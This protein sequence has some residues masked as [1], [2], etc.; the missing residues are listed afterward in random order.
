MRS[1]AARISLTSVA[2]QLATVGAN[3][4]RAQGYEP[5]RFATPVNLGD[6]GEAYQ[7]GKE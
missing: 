7:R 3:P 1:I 6:Q 5:I 2:A 4:A